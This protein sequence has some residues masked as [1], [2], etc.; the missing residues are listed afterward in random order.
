MKVFLVARPLR[1][2]GHIFLS[3]FFF[4]LQKEFFFLSGPAFT[5][6]LLLVAIPLKKYFFAAFLTKSVSIFSDLF[7]IIIICFK[8]RENKFCLC[9]YKKILVSKMV[10]QN[11]LRKYGGNHVFFLDIRL[12]L[13]IALDRSNCQFH[14]TRAHL[15]LSC[16]ANKS[17]MADAERNLNF[18]NHALFG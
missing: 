6:P 12:I 17:T 3:V 16:H 2:R 4:D 14:S 18:L 9:I 7:I 15:R 13:T 10:A 8:T 5:T 1:L 11:T